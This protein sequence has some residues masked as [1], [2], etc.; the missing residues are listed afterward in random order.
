MNEKCKMQNE[1][2]GARDGG[3]RVEDGEMLIKKIE[4]GEI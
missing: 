3:S 1:G 2:L 4:I